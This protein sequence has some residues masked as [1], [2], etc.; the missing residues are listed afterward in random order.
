MT[1]ENAPEVS[2]VIR[3]PRPLETQTPLQRN[4]PVLIASPRSAHGQRAAK[5]I[6]GALQDM[7]LLA[8]ILEDPDSQLLREATSP[9]VV[10]G[11]LAD[12]RSVRML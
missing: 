3:V 12:S 6:H 8:R 2:T 4:T 5:S 1:S 9:I 11:N 10:V 7:G